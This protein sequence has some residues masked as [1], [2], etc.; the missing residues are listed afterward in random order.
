MLVNNI[1]TLILMWINLWISIAKNFWITK[2]TVNSSTLANETCQKTQ[3]LAP[4]QTVL[5]FAI[6][7]IPPKTSKKLIFGNL[8]LTFSH[9][10]PFLTI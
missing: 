4:S 8:S 3:L 9:F 5:P 6:C 2:K 10:C 7:S 1:L